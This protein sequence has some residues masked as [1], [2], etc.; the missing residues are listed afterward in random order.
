MNFP[1]KEY[2]DLIDWQQSPITDPPILASNSADDT[3]MFV[4]AGD[5]PLINVPKYPCHTQAVER[6]VKL[7]TEACLSVCRVKER[8]GFIH[9]KLESR[10]IMPSFYQNVTVALLDK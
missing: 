3:E 4:F 8:D 2:I 6:W 7:V 5:I 10:Q 9:V 1:A